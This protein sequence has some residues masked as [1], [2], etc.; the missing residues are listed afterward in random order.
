ML[1]SYVES[2]ISPDNSLEYNILYA[3]FQP[4]LQENQNIW[5][6]L[7]CNNFCFDSK[8]SFLMSVEIY[9]FLYCEQLLFKDHAHN[10]LFVRGHFTNFRWI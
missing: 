3:E 6:R 8:T 5:E 9:D 7:Y 4:K 2:N 10:L 1:G